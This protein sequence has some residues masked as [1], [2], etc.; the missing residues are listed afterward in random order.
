MNEKQNT[1]PYYKKWWFW[2]IVVIVLI[3]IGSF[4][5]DE[6]NNEIQEPAQNQEEQSNIDIPQYS[7]LRKIEHI[8]TRMSDDQASYFGGV[9]IEGNAMDISP[10]EFTEIARE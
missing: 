1:K 7:V 3:L 9:L 10:E 4:I 8:S 2:G 5:A 6:G